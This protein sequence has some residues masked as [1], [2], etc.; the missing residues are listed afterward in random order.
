MKT[1]KDISSLKSHIQSHPLV[2]LMISS[3]GC[4]VC[5]SILAQMTNFEREHSNVEFVMS[6]LDDMPNLSGEFVVFTVPTILVFFEG[7]EILR[8]SRFIDWLKLDKV[9]TMACQ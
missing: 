7:R 8:M 2:L 3:S 5:D 1:F 6:K 9:L 4:N